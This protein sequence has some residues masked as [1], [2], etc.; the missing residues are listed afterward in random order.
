MEP[1]ILSIITFSPL[2][3]AL[4][5]LFIPREEEWEIKLLATFSTFCSFILSL[6]L[7]VTFDRSLGS[8]TLQFVER[9]PWIPKLGISYIMGVDGFNA[10]MVLLSGILAF[11]CIL[12]SFRITH[13]TK[14]YF[15]LTLVCLTGVIG[16]FSTQDLFF[17]VVFYEMASIPMYFLIGIWGSDKSGNGK[18]VKKE[19]AALKLTLYLQ[20][21]GGLV[22][23]GILGVYFLTVLPQGMQRTFF[24]HDLIQ[25]GNLAKHYQMILFPLIFLG[26]AIEAGF[27]P[28]HTWLPDGHSA[29]PTALSMILAGVLLKMG[30]YG[31]LKIAIGLAPQGALVWLDIFIAF[32]VINIIYGALCAMNQTDI[33]YMIAYSSVS[34]MGFVTLGI[35]ARNTAGFNGAIF[36][37]FSHGIITALLFAIAGLLYEKA[38]TRSMPKLGGLAVKMPYLATFFILGG[39]A[40]LGLPGMSGFVAEFLVFIAVFKAHYIIAGALAITGIVLTAIYILRAVQRIFFGALPDGYLDIKDLTGIEGSH[41]VLLSLVMIVFGVYPRLLIDVMSPS[42]EYLRRLLMGQ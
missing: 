6:Y 41:L 39:L 2:L 42:T 40:S 13:R 7:F 30:G 24:L 9:I 8:E 36:Q 20:L 4:L 16:V 18:T 3:G 14:E 23:L 32:G 31:M 34:H 35:A 11:A 17:F 22:L 38:H 28:L 25:Y 37:M 15:I 21:G 27:W 10:P 1:I 29:A 19:Y 5:I 33:K 26:F 12:A